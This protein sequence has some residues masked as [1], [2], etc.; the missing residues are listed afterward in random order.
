MKVW[1]DDI[2]EPWRYGCLGWTWVKTYAEAVELL[3]T[4]TVTQISLDHDLAWEHYPGSG[5]SEAGYK[6]KTGRHVIDW[7]EE[8]SVWPEKISLHTMNPAG[9]ENMEKILKRNRQSY[10][11]WNLTSRPG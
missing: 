6:E 1:L 9:R 4:G 10:Q 7:M 2:R 11:V 3:R 8:H 5:V